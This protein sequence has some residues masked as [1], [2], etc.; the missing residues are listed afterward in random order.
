MILS[1]IF[2][3]IAT[4]FWTGCAVSLLGMLPVDWLSFAIGMGLALAHAS[5][6]MWVILFEDVW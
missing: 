1:I 2:N 5:A 6:T 3:T 4:L